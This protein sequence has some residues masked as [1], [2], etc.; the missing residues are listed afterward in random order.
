MKKKL[1]TTGGRHAFDP[2]N[3]RLSVTEKPTKPAPAPAK[4]GVA[5]TAEKTG[6]TTKPKPADKGKGE[7]S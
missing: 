4:A 7:P 5:D 3:G 2:E 6:R 1:P